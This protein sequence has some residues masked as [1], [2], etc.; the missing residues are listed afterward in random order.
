MSDLFAKHADR[1]EA[2]LEAIQ[3]EPDLKRADVVLVTDGEAGVSS[4]FAERWR[5]ARGK[6]GFTTY[7]VHVASPG[8]VVPPVLEAVADKTIGLADIT[9]DT[10]AT[11]TLLGL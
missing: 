11:E 7:A 3:R 4:D 1:L 10:Q 9:K 8:G 2:A 6:F 5:K